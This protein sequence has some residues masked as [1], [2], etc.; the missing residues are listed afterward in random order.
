MSLLLSLLLAF[1]QD[2]P[3]DRL[4]LALD[5][6]DPVVRS[7]A[8]I[9]L[10]KRLLD[11]G[12][13][14][15]VTLDRIRDRG[16][17]E[18][19]AR[20]K[21]L[22]ELLVKVDECR[23]RLA[24]F[25]IL[26]LPDCRGKTWILYNTGSW[27]QSDDRVRFSYHSGWKL[28]DGED[29]PRMLD[30]SL[31]ERTLF[32]FPFSPPEDWEEKHRKNHPTDRPLP[33]R[34]LEVDF[35]AFCRGILRAVEADDAV[36]E[37][38]TTEVAELQ[39]AVLAYWA[40]R[41]GLPLLALELEKSAVVAWNRTHP[42]EKPQEL[43]GFLRGE[44]AS[45]WRNRAIQ[46]AS[47]RVSRAD[48]LKDWKAVATLTPDHAEAKALIP[49]YERLIREDGDVKPL[50]EAALAALPRADQ[51]RR[52]IHELR[53]LNQVLA[54]PGHPDFYRYAPWRPGQRSADRELYLL[55]LDA[56]P[57]LID[58]FDDPSPT[59]IALPREG[60]TLHL[61]TVGEVCRRIFED[62]STLQ[63][64]D[65][66]RA[67]EWLA[68]SRR[69]GEE[70]F[71]LGLLGSESRAALAA[72]NLLRLDAPKHLPRVL[73]LLEQNP[74]HTLRPFLAAAA[75]FLGKSHEKL[76][77]TLM[78]AG[79]GEL[80]VDAARVLW[81]RCA[82]EKG[83]R[84]LLAR[85][86]AGAFRDP[87]SQESIDLLA[88]VGADWALDGICELA[89]HP[90]FDLRWAAMEAAASLPSRK[91]AEAL[92]PS[93]DVRELRGIFGPY[94]MRECDLAAEALIRML[95]LS[96]TIAYAGPVDHRDRKIGELHA[97]WR[98]NSDSIDWDAL[99]RSRK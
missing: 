66:D 10:Q 30:T 62:L 22:R 81:T 5:D 39:P 38:G 64:R 60:T 71:Y 70:A 27:I 48:V 97:W 6:D 76:L 94:P 78:N 80:E 93:L 83:P 41:R 69:S 85:L 55:G 57:L 73:E 90:S 14:G 53:D 16:S 46:R 1:S 40:L 91:S 20:L 34:T 74:P 18:V 99:R 24:P 86:S 21:E 28:P 31:E 9:A 77:E 32:D 65:P 59:R 35:E 58:R 19:R 95:D 98:K 15:I 84:H 26:D 3:L 7:R 11:E 52:W 61:L 8:A 47:W 89:R 82:S 23:K 12:P 49:L 92:L 87:L 4:L 68:A 50:D 43:P 44:L 29:G 45:R 2:A 13:D 63:E 67:R 17:A 56:A 37:F 42:G 54:P 88:A 79:N 72:G 51:A 75:P 96:K 33:G 25:E 36:S